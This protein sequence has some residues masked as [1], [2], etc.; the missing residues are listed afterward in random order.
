MSVVE[1][2]SRLTAETTINVLFGVVREKMISVMGQRMRRWVEQLRSQVV[3]PLGFTFGEAHARSHYPTT[4]F[5]AVC[6]QTSSSRREV[7]PALCFPGY[8]CRCANFPEERLWTAC[9]ALKHGGEDDSPS[10]GLGSAL[11]SRLPMIR[12]KLH[13]GLAKCEFVHLCEELVDDV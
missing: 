4:R 6:R 8:P 7:D 9:D 12:E 5:V 2:H 1:E 10:G 13:G 11:I 3:Y